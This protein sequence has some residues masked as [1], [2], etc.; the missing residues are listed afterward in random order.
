MNNDSSGIIVAY[1][2]A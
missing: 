1:V 2:Y